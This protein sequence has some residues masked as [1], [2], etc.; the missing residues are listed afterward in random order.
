MVN[1]PG[2]AIMSVTDQFAQIDISRGLKN[3]ASK[4][5]LF[6]LQ[7]PKADQLPSKYRKKFQDSLRR[8]R[9]DQSDNSRRDQ[10]LESRV[11]EEVSLDRSSVSRNN[12]LR[13]SSRSDVSVDRT[14]NSTKPAPVQSSREIKPESRVGENDS[15]NAVNNQASDATAVASQDDIQLIEDSQASE[16]QDVLSDLNQAFSDLEIPEAPAGLKNILNIANEFSDDANLNKPETT[17]NEQGIKPPISL[18]KA[19]DT[20]SGQDEVVPSGGDS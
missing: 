7:T 12:E 13:D 17:L 9:L 15:Q 4:L 20:V 1:E 3:S 16:E 8:K 6:P 2:G 14:K 18:F 5:E 11:R 19:V 10:K